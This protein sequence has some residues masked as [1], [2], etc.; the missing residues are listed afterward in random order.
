LSLS[1]PLILASQSPR[2]HALLQKI[3][4]SFQ[5]QVSPA[6][7]VIEE[8]MAPPEQARRLADRKAA[9]VAETHPSSLVLA[10][11]TIVAHEGAALGKPSSPDAAAEMLRRLSGTTH[12]VYTGVALH[13]RASR[14][15]VSTTAE[16]QV[17]FATLSDREISSYVATGSPMDK[18]GGYG[19]QDHTG[20]LF[21]ERIEGD[22]YTVVGLP[23]RRVYEMVGANFEDLLVS[24]EGDTAPDHR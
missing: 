19:I 5:V 2:R 7:E 4:L 17:T 8:P 16:T 1:V 6:D 23:L 12:H 13:H 11:D 22:Y 21:V 18:A 20:P 15:A 10:A 24:S 14:R 9:P 3:N